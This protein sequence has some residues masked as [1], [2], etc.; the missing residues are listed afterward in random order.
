[1][2]FLDHSFPHELFKHLGTDSNNTYV[3]QQLRQAPK[4]Q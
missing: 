2:N 1:M 4:S 3:S